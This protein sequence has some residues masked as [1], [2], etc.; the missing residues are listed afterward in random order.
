MI[1]EFRLP[2]LGEGVHEGEI[3]AV[4]VSVGDKVGEDDPILEVET[5]KAAVEIT[6]PFSG[7]VTGIQVEPGD[8]VNVGDV[9]ITFDGGIGPSDSALETS[10]IDQKEGLVDSNTEANGLD[11]SRMQPSGPVP[12]SPATRRLA[13]ELGVDLSKV[14]GS[15]PGGRISSGDVRAFAQGEFGAAVGQPTQEVRS[16]DLAEPIQSKPSIEQFPRTRAPRLPDFGRWGQVERVP[17]R[18][19]RRSTA[20]HMAVAWSQVPHVSH[21]DVADVTELEA[22]RQKY[23]D[24]I[25]EQ[26]GRLTMTVLVIKATVAALKA[27]PRFNSSLDVEGEEIVLKKYYNIGVA[28]DT[29][30]GLLVPVVHDADCKSIPELAIELRELVARTREGKASIEDLQGGTFTIT[31]PGPLGGTGFAAIVNYPEVAILGMARAGWQ[32]VVR[33]EGKDGQ[34]VPRF[35][36]PL[37]LSFDHR[38]VDGA[39][40]ARFVNTIIEGLQDPGR[41]LMRV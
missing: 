38:V 8:L 36:L 33:G 27:H 16:E 32:P 41:L 31:N 14:R 6:S 13:R 28:V 3:V 35:T 2:D 7:T 24:E 17:L 21:R 19:V 22:L 12:A 30:R 34:I 15:G 37:A 4:L 29:E 1:R 11:P 20:R 9:L 26:G 10:R 18:S 5:D 25:A 40:A 23:K 39:D